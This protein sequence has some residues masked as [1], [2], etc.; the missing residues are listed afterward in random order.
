MYNDIRYKYPKMLWGKYTVE[1]QEFFRNC[2]GSKKSRQNYEIIPQSLGFFFLFL[3][4]H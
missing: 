4:P 3:G 1:I 2:I